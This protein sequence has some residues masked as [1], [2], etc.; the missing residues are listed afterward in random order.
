MKAFV[1]TLMAAAVLT[2]CGGSSN[3][4]AS[5][6]SNDDL[7][8]S[9]Q[10]VD[11]PIVGAKVCLF[12]NGLQATNKAGADVCSAETD[13]GGSYTLFIPG[14]LSAGLLHLVAVKGSDI[15]LASVLGSLDDVRKVAKKNELT[16]ENLAAVTVT[17]FTTADFALADKDNNGIVSEKELKEYMPDLEETM[18]IASII[19]A[20]VDFK[21]DPELKDQVAELIGGNTLD[22]LELAKAAAKKEKLGSSNKTAEEWLAL[23]VN[24][25]VLSAVIK[26]VAQSITVP[27]FDYKFSQTAKSFKVP[28]KVEWSEG[29]ASIFCGFEENLDE[30]Q[31][32]GIVQIALDEARRVAV[33]KFDDG[34]EDDSWQMVGNYD[35][36]SGAVTFNEYHSPEISQEGEF[37]TFYTDGSLKLN[38]IYDKKYGNIQGAYTEI[39]AT[40]WTLDSTRAECKATGVFKAVRQ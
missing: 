38:G 31:D 36:K 3:D 1:L 16:S 10:V 2:A 8:I 12:S 7:K 35:P 37:A 9:G 21:S 32:E 30:E 5:K 19:K 13:G 18:K 22:T 11:G 15:K 39:S 26:D 33:M 27:F 23:P 14:H 20:V 17:H 28:A 34:E 24:N 29:G 4:K 25:K 6:S 40:T